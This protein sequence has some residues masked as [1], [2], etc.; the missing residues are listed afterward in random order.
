MAK[1]AE[2]IPFGA[3]H[4]YISHI[5]ECPLGGG[6]CVMHSNIFSFEVTNFT[7]LLC[8]P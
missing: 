3:A 4:I 1:T 8:N 5:R 6:V 2:N 7:I